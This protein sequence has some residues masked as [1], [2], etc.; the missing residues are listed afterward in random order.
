M[1]GTV[2]LQQLLLLKFKYHAWSGR[3]I[4]SLSGEPWW[5]GIWLSPSKQIRVLDSVWS[6]LALFIALMLTELR[7]F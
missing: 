4:E 7:S 3:A 1:N 6:S 5:I 2:L